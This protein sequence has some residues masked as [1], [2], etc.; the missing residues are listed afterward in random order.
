MKQKIDNHDEPMSLLDKFSRLK[1]KLFAKVKY[2]H[3]HIAL[4]TLTPMLI[5]M[6]VYLYDKNVECDAA[7]P[8]Q[9][10]FQD[11]ASPIAEGI[12]RFHH[13]LII[14]LIMVTIFVTWMLVRCVMMYNENSQKHSTGN[15]HGTVL[16]VVW[17]VVPGLIL[18]LIAIPSFALLYS[19]DEIVDPSM[20]LKIIGHQWYWSYE[21]GDFDSEDG[22]SI[23]FDSYILDAESVSSGKLRMLEVDNRVPLPVNVHIRLIVTSSDVLHSWT[24]PSFGVKMD[25]CPGRLNQASVFITREGTFFGQCSEICGVGHGFMPIC[26]KSMPMIQFLEWIVEEGGVLKVNRHEPYVMY[27]NKNKNDAELIANINDDFFDDYPSRYGMETQH[28][29]SKRV[30]NKLPVEEVAMPKM[31][32]Q[33]L[34]RA[35][36][37][38]VEPRVRVED[39][40]LAERVLAGIT[41]KV[42]GDLDV[43]LIDSSDE[44]PLTT[45]AITNT[46]NTNKND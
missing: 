43:D 35:F 6:I 29:L 27:F 41:A 31:P 44:S 11:P 40:E 5:I 10:G 19:V 18:V 32:K 38:I 24:V 33:S 9:Y 42:K 21:Y 15:V 8:W 7:T 39:I 20:T 12:V 36:T 3:Q 4:S 46:T 30:Q 23:G 16:E 25:A 34:S 22:D 17:T 13:D 26:V 37:P 28:E 2:K 14:V 45:I 1:N